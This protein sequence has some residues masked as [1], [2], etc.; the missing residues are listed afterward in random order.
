MFAEADEGKRQKYMGVSGKLSP[1]EIKL[2]GSFL[3]EMVRRR[4]RL[5]GDRIVVLKL[6]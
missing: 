6:S 4:D 5:S 1:V 2:L 3:L